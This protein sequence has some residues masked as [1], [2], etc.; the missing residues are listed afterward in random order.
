MKSTYRRKTEE[1]KRHRKSTTFRKK[2]RKS[3]NQRKAQAMNKPQKHKENQ[4]LEAS[5]QESSTS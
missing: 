3:T 4:V 5:T 2:L 1:I